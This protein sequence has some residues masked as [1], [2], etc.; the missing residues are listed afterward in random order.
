MDKR[1]DRMRTIGQIRRAGNETNPVGRWAPRGFMIGLIVVAI[2]ASGA[3]AVSAAL[4][5][6]VQGP[7]AVANG[8]K[9]VITSGPEKYPATACASLSPT[10]ILLSTTKIPGMMQ[11]TPATATGGQSLS[12][13]GISMGIAPPAS[14][15]SAA[16]V[17]EHL[18]NSSAPASAIQNPDPYNVAN[19][20]T[21][22]TFDE[23]ITG[24]TNGA[25]ESFFFNRAASQQAPTDNVNGKVQSE[26]M[27]VQQNVTGLPAPNIVVTTNQPGTD[28]PGSVQVTIEEGSTI[29][30]FGF[31][32]GSSLVLS[33]VLSYVN[34]GLSQAQV[35]CGARSIMP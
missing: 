12:P 31:S 5:P 8:A 25:A 17:S 27:G 7:K 3:V 33:D 18:F 9:A 11:G 24:F 21:V 16:V 26:Q 4:S 22:T 1:G 14:N 30:G 35:T 10:S 34:L 13:F 29:F 19:P 15:M 23:G 6:S 28:V 20:H 2:A 32:G